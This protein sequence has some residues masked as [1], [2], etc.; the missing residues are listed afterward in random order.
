[1]KNKKIKQQQVQEIDS[2]DPIVV[3]LE[4]KIDRVEAQYFLEDLDELLDEYSPAEKLIEE[5]MELESYNNQ[6][7][8][9]F[10]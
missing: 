1:M 3:T 5:K 6:Y 10:S 8:G 2:F 9:D 4:I 7:N